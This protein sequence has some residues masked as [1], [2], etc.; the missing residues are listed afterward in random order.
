MAESLDN[1]VFDSRSEAEAGSESEL[2]SAQE[3]D[4]EPLSSPVTGLASSVT[5]GKRKKYVCVYKREYSR[6]YPWAAESKKGKTFA[7]CMPCGRDICLDQG[8]TTL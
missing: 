3:M 6:R 4:I 2:G 7:Y 1:F 8:G 5:D